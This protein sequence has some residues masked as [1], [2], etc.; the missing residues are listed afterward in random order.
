MSAC[1]KRAWDVPDIDLEPHDRALYDMGRWV[2]S[3]RG[4]EIEYRGGGRGWR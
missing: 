4:R 3:K 1:G 2:F